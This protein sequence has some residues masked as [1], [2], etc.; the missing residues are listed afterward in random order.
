MGPEVWLRG[1]GYV[2][3]LVREYGLG[4]CTV[5]QSLLR[6]SPSGRGPNRILDATNAGLELGCPCVVIHVPFE[7]RWDCPEAQRWVRTVESCRERT[8]GTGTRLALENPVV[9]SAVDRPGVLSQLP[10]LTEFA[11][12]N[13]L[14]IAFD[15]C[16]AGT[17]E[18]ELL[19]AYDL[20]RD[21]LVDIHLSDLCSATSARTHYWQDPFRAHRMPGEGSLPLAGFLSRLAEDDF[22]GPLTIEVSPIAL[23]FW[24]RRQL[25]RRLAR[26]ADYAL[27]AIECSSS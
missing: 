7:T 8:S 11:K 15:T 26:A 1:T 10:V 14:G 12:R 23:R 6:I 9:A 2:A 25:R 18:I 22:Q 21:L 20:I 16:H 5:H 13:D 19:D 4:V 24:S 3:S 17:Q 27:R